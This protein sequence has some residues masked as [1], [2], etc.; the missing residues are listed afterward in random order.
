[1]LY[2]MRAL[3]VVFA[4]F[5]G[6]FILY[7]IADNSN[8][9][10]I[11]LASGLLIAISAILFEERVKKTPLRIVLGGAAGLITGLI[12]ANLITYPIVAFI[13]HP[14]IDSLVYLL[15]NCIIGYMG[16]SVGMKKGDDL[17][18]VKVGKKKFRLGHDNEEHH[19]EERAAPEIAVP[20]PAVHKVLMDT[21][22]IIDGRISDICKIG[23]IPGTILIPKFVLEELHNIADSADSTRRTRGK[24]GL[25]ILQQLKESAEVEVEITEQDVAEGKPVDSKLVALGKELGV[26]ILTN[27]SNLNKVAELQGVGVLSINKLANALKPVV[28]PGERLE[29]QVMKQGKEPGQGVGYLDD[30]TMV[31][32]DDG[33]EAVGKLVIVTITSVL[34]TAGGKMIFSKLIE[35]D[36][37]GTG[38]VLVHARS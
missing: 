37:K 20:E 34:Q 22:V 38:P 15:A 28:L 6:Y 21:S 26:K 18:E 31:V 13:E 24:R 35:K 30:G 27:D 3:L 7:Q 5:S 11:G 36:A 25:D 9:A 8:L 32:I 33:S 19:E 17:K 23:F 2:A 4:S 14:Y 10:Y 16:L 12:V 29:L 1:M